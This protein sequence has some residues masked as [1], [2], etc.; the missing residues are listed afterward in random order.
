MPP[1]SPFRP[2][3]PQL[4]LALATVLAYAVGYPLALVAGSP[5]G[6]VLVTLGGFLLL[7]FG[8]VTIQR[9]HRSGP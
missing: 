9:I 2:D 1:R 6:W 7:A 4:V 8:V 5:F 3:R